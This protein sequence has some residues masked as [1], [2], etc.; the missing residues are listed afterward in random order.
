MG[1]TARFPFTIG[2]WMQV[3]DS[4]G[5]HS[6]IKAYSASETS[7]GM[8]PALIRVADVDHNIS[9][10]VMLDAG[11]TNALGGTQTFGVSAEG[12]HTFNLQ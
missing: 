7:W 12:P 11:F 8:T 5:K 6:Q 10:P 4:S 1:S 3:I 9:D 2:A